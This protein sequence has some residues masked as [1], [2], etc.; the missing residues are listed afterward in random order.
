MCPF[1]TFSIDSDGFSLNSKIDA[2]I[3]LSSCRDQNVLPQHVRHDFSHNAK[4]S[5][6]GEDKAPLYLL[7]GEVSEP[8]DWRRHQVELYQVSVRP[9]VIAAIEAGLEQ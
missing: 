9:Q 6:L 2:A 3:D 7:D 5:V 4:V 8:A 1:L